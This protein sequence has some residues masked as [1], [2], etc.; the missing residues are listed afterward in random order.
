[1]NSAQPPFGG[2][3]VHEVVA[4]RVAEQVLEVQTVR[5]AV[6]GEPGGEPLAQQLAAL[7]EPELELLDAGGA[8]NVV[9][10]ILAVLL[11]LDALDR[12][13]Q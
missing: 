2:L 6:A 5:L 8:V 9:H 4:C 7:P 10:D 12:P 11:P 13:L 3:A 1:M